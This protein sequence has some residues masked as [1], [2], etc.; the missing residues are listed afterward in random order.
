MTHNIVFLDRDSLIANVRRPSFPHS[1]TEYAASSGAEAA[2]RLHGATIAI[3]NKVPLRADTLERLPDLRLIAVAATGTD[4]VDLAAARA[5]GIVV[6]NIR[7]YAH[8]TVPEHTF[9]L[10]LALRRNL[11]AYRLDVEAGKWQKSE[12]FCLFDHPITDLNGSRLGLLGYGALGRAVARLGRAFGMEVMVHKRTPVDDPDVRNVSWDELLETSDV[13]S[14]HAPLTGQ[15]RDIIGAAE[16]E[17]MKRSALLINT[18]RGGLVDEAALAAAL[19]TGVIAGAGFD[20]LAKEPPPED[21]VLLNLRLPNFILTPHMAWASTQAMQG[22]ADQL[23]D[24]I[25][26]YAANKPVNVVG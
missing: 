17:R 22:L 20:V 16:L 19:T 2:Q 4:I 9:A 3:T 14:L 11:L 5:R 1:W 23:I 8:A 13:L 24:N 18:A 26:A 25:E 21:N 10:I 12:R 15:T 6:S 7:D